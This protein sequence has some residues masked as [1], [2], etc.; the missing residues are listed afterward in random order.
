MES[1]KHILIEM[2]GY[3]IQRHEFHGAKHTFRLPLGSEILATATEIEGSSQCAY[4]YARVMDEDRIKARWNVIGED[5]EAEFEVRLV[6]AIEARQL[7]HEEGYIFLGVLHFIDG[8]GGVVV[9][10]DNGFCQKMESTIQLV[11]NPTS[12]VSF[13][14]GSHQIASASDSGDYIESPTGSKTLET[15]ES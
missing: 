11:T 12:P 1:S 5:Y 9:Y 2:E 7:I 4:I 13:S 6:H 10:K 3:D 15:P 14:H 8:A